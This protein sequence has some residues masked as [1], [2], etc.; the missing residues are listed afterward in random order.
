MAP[1]N[2]T[3][4]FD[5]DDIKVT[6]KIPDHNT[7]ILGYKIV[8]KGDDGTIRTTT[9]ENGQKANGYLP[10][11]KKCVNYM[12]GVRS[13]SIYTH[14]EYSYITI[15]ACEGKCTSNYHI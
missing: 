6:W 8:G 4:Q 9:T 3:A 12:V 15:K 11:M 13:E 7:K 2:I 14:S 10:A 1:T 5:N